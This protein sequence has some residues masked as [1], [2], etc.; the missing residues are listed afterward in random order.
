MTG[1]VLLA[2]SSAFLAAA[3]A[4]AQGSDA[5]I[6]VEDAW[7]RRAPMMDG[8]SKAGSGNGA[9]YAVLVN[10][11]TQPD[12]LVGA[13]SD[14]AAAVE[15]HESYRDMGMMMMRPVRKI[16]VPAGKKVEMKPG[17]FHI[18]L[19]NLKREL[20]AGQVVSLTL[21]FDKAGKIPVSAVVR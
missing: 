7:A 1:R 3:S 2:I 14:A 19:V 10:G 18:M 21:Q 13:A 11:G 12:A 6:L 16:D 9:V 17:G 4:C 15:I 5:K 8:D 20:K